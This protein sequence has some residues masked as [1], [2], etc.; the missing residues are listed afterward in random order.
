MNENK[1]SPLNSSTWSD[2]VKLLFRFLKAER[3][4]IP[5]I[6][7]IKEQRGKT[8]TLFIHSSVHPHST[9]SSI[10]DSAFT[11]DETTEGGDFW[12]DLYVKAREI[13]GK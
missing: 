10:I 3:A 13:S 2:T 9:V 7:A 11:W 6:S 4:F 8:L 5:F 12:Y 1:R